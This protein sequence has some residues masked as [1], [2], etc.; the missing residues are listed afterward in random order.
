MVIDDDVIR[1][2]SDEA[3]N[4]KCQ[5][6][7]EHGP[8]PRHW[9]LALLF[10]TIHVNKSRAAGSSSVPAAR[11]RDPALGLV[12][13]PCVV[14]PASFDVRLRTRLRVVTCDVRL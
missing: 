6:T 13:T 1:D 12:T 5:M 8:R 2:M 7:C 3:S 11:S 9:P 14:R 10:G 4:V